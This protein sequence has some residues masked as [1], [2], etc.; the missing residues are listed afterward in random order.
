MPQLETLNGLAVDREELYNEGEEQPEEEE[1]EDKD[2]ETSELKQ[3]IIEMW[4]QSDKNPPMN[5]SF[6]GQP[7]QTEEEEES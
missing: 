7:G 3:E 6:G 1:D 5:E 2:P 4:N